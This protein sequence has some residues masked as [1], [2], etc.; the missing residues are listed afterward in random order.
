HG[1]IEAS[2][3]VFLDQQKD[4]IGMLDSPPYGDARA[5][6]MK[7]HEDLKG[8]LVNKF[9]DFRIFDEDEIISKGLLGLKGEKPSSNSSEFIGVPLD[10]SVYVYR[11]KGNY[12]GHKGHHGALLQDEMEIPVINLRE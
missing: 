5:V 1:F 4:V 11:Y 2:K 12:S 9:N 10:N 7:S 8:K 3:A 6:F